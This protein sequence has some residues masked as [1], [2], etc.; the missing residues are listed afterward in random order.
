MSRWRVVPSAAEIIVR[1]K[2]W[3]AQFECHNLDVPAIVKIEITQ[4]HGGPVTDLI[5][6][7]RALAQVLTKAALEDRPTDETG[8]SVTLN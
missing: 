8:T 4:Q 7:L 6:A 5:S 2:D 3:T 1:E